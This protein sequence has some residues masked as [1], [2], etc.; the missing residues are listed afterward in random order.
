MEEAKVDSL[1]EELGRTRESFEKAIDTIKW[2]RVNNA[3]LYSLCAMLVMV[4][5]LSYNHNENQNR[6]LC[7]RNNAIRAATIE[8]LDVTAT[9][10]GT[11]FATVYEVPIE[12]LDRFLQVYGEQDP[13]VA[14]QQREC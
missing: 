13:P 14:L 2:R 10:I 7:E 4:V 9:K 12:D 1:I 11:S 6:A 5:I 8:A 3:L